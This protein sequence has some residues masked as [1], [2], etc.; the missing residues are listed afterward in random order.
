MA[1]PSST[2][3]G[4]HALPIPSLRSNQVDCL[5]QGGLSFEE[6]MGLAVYPWDEESTPPIHTLCE[7]PPSPTAFYSSP[8]RGAPCPWCFVFE[9]PE[10]L[11]SP[12]F[13]P[14]TAKWPW[15]DS[16]SLPCTVCLIFKTPCGLALSMLST[17]V[18]PRP[19][20]VKSPFRMAHKQQR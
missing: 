11:A 14:S 3:V 10:L 19:L 9:D 16:G 17:S 8:D 18:K 1:W 4:S 7:V 2:Q 5:P 20:E 15:T 6:E 12:D 13:V